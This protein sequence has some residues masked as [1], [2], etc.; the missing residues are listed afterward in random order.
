M[1]ELSEPYLTILIAYYSLITDDNVLTTFSSLL[2]TY[3][4]QP[5][6]IALIKGQSKTH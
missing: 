2:Y 5:R 1:N 4:R 3:I 6:R